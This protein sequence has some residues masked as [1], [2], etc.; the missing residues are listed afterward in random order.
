MIHDVVPPFHFVSEEMVSDSSSS[1]T[2]HRVGKDGF[3]LWFHILLFESKR[4]IT[5]SP[6]I[7]IDVLFLFQ[8]SDNGIGYRRKQN[9]YE[10]F[11]NII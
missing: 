3:F 4:I 9:F 10:T 5:Y 11:K 8:K 2:M 1:G 6:V 7:H